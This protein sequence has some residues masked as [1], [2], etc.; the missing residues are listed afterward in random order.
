MG[1]KST[2]FPKHAY[3]L[4][5]Q[6]KSPVAHSSNSISTAG[7]SE[8]PGD[9]PRLSPLTDPT[10]TVQTFPSLDSQQV[11]GLVAETGSSPGLDSL[12]CSKVLQRKQ[13]RPHCKTKEEKVIKLLR[14]QWLQ[15]PIKPKH[16]VLLFP[17]PKIIVLFSYFV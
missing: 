17:L 4:T 7:R 15:I 10:H 16:L 5:T 1:L 2:Q 11:L 3:P 13:I 14:P 9:S 12:Q 6:A 8:A